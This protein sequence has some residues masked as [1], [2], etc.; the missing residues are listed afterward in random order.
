MKQKEMLQNIHY[1]VMLG[2]S[3]KTKEK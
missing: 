1:C 3:E 2:L